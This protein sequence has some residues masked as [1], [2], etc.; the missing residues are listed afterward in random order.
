MSTDTAEYDL[1]VRGR[2]IVTTAGTVA[3]EVG[4][5]DGRVV[6]IEP[7]GNGLAGREVIELTDD[8]VLI[9]GLV[10]THVHVNEPGRTEWEGFESATKAAAAGGVTTLVDMPLNSIPPTVDREA[11]RIK[12]EVAGPK[13]HIDVGFWGGAVPGNKGELRGLH[14][15][16]VFGFKCFLLHSGVDEFPHLTADEMEE[17]MAELATFDSLMI[18]HAED[19]R[20]I[21]HAPEPEGDKYA[22]FLASR[23]RGAENVAIADVIERARWTGARAH[24]LH[25]SSSDAL[26]MIA[27]A[28][29]DGVKLTV[30]T[31]PHYLTLLAEEIPNG[32]TAYK[33]C[34]P[35]REASNRELLWQGLLDGT[36]D[37]IVSDHS[38]STIDLKDVENGDFGVAWGGVASLQLGLQLIWTEAKKRGISLEQVLEWMSANPAKLAGMTRKGRIALGFDADFAIF[39]PEAAQVVDVHHLHHKNAISPYDG[40]ALAGVISGTWLRGEKVDFETPHGRLLRRGEA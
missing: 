7:L 40:R 34:P 38:P 37:C 16:G 33:C 13:A 15:D 24:I 29:R 11:L 28:R 39:E 14:D 19:S 8:Q 6:A 18:V 27:T 31:C 36:I 12:R 17:D 23:P 30:E 20:A 2:R 35:I 26:P 10:D 21:D 22:K 4:I 1:V 9:P 25:L 3:R 32:G 5:R